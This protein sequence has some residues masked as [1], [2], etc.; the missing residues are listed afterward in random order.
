MS[1]FHFI[2]RNVYRQRTNDYFLRTTITISVR[3]GQRVR[4]KT[5]DN[6]PWSWGAGLGADAVLPL[7]WVEV[8]VWLPLVF[9][10]S[11]IHI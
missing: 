7:R 5:P 2:K 11:G 10:K 8:L 3:D 1:F 4:G 9:V 6:A